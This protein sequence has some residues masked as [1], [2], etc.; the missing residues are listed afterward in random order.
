MNLNE[1]VMERSKKCEL[2][3]NPLRC[4]IVAFI[5][6]KKEATWSQLKRTLEEWAGYVNPNT[7]SFHLGELI[8]EGFIDKVDV[9]GQPIYK[10]VEDK[11]SEIQR[12]IG[13]DL[14]KKMEET[15]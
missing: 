10:I 7:L 9:E 15:L 12:L 2:F 11:L 5:T 1:L 13:E 3:S 14:I 6:A 8:K 4:F